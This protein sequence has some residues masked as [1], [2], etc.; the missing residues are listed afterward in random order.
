MGP[1][2]ESPDGGHTVY[3]RDT[4]TN[5]RTLIHEDDYAKKVKAKIEWN[6]I[7]EVA[8]SNS[9]LKK[10]VDNVI[11]IYRLSEGK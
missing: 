8:D 1:I 2:Y 4:G 3:V 9:A 10:A 5:S 6:H 7:F 11:M